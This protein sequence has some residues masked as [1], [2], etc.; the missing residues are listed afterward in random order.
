MVRNDVRKFVEPELRERREDFAFSFN[1][2]RDNT[3]ECGNA[4]GRDDE[5]AIAVNL[6]NVSN[7]ATFN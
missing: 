1:R 4:I 5:E 2:R 7:L 6:I 3:I